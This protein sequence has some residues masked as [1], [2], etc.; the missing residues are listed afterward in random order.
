[1]M[2]RDKTMLNKQT[3]H[4]AHVAHLEGT[5]CTNVSLRL[6]PDTL[7]DTISIAPSHL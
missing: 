5:V 7:L 1:M 3:S 4:T 6:S 2:K